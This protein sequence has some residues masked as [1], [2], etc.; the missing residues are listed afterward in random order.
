[1]TGC[2]ECFPGLTHAIAVAATASAR[3]VRPSPKSLWLIFSASGHRP[4]LAHAA[5]FMLLEGSPR[6]ISRA[7]AM[8]CMAMHL[9]AP[10][11]YAHFAWLRNEACLPREIQTAGPCASP[12][13][14][15]ARAIWLASHGVFS[16]AAAYQ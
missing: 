12:S 13:M 6:L 11:P 2:I 16:C 15:A 4:E 10:Q 3:A 14:V 9:S 7:I 1:M 8:G 5:P